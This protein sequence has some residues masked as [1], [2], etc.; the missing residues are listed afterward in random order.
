MSIQCNICANYCNISEGSFGICKQH[1][2]VNGEL[3]DCSYG[4]ISSAAVDSIE[5]KP[6]YHFLPRTKTYSIG[7]IGCNMAC[8]HCQNYIISQGYVDLVDTIKITPSMVVENALFNNCKSIAFT[9]N[10]PTIH[11]SFYRDV[12]LL[13]REKNLK[14]VFVSNGYFSQESLSEILNFVDAF[15]IDLKSISSDFYKK[16]CKVDRDVVLENIKKIYR[17]G[18]HLEITNLIINNLNDSFS[19]MSQLV[20]FVS[21]ELDTSIPL[22]FTRS[23]PYYKMQDIEPTKKETLLKAEEIAKKDKIENVYI[24]NTPLNNNSF[25]PQCGELL[26]KRNGFSTQNMNNIV[27]GYCKTCH[28]KL[29][30][31]ID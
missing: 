22:H 5:K 14:I 16:I 24:R 12:A 19:D 15:N 23:F 30:F 25:C 7:G 18:K 13:A 26:F 2:N 27:D 4:I 21:N 29:N 17:A 10:E 6:L 9:Y 20:N 28:F 8:L 3:V 1:K 11:L 31:V